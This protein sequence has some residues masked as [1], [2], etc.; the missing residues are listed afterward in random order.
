MLF[1][2]YNGIP[3]GVNTRP[4]KVAVSPMGTLCAG[5]LGRGGL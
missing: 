2:I 1:L 4:N 3:F 5:G